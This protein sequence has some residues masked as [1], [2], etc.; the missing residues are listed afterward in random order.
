MDRFVSLRRE[1]SRP[2][3]WQQWME[4]AAVAS[5]I[6]CP[7][8]IPY[9]N[10]MKLIMEVDMTILKGASDR[11]GRTAEDSLREFL[12]TGMI[13]GRPLEPPGPS[14]PPGPTETP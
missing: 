2:K 10:L 3:A 14:D 13:A 11:P 4:D 9:D 6:L 8:V 12:S 7:V 1:G 5:P